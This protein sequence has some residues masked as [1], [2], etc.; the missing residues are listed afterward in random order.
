MNT[1]NYTDLIKLKTFEERFEYLRLRGKVG[2]DTFGFDRYLNQMLYHSAEWKNFKKEILVRDL[3]HD[4]AMESDDYIIPG[5][6]TVHHII[7][8]TA[9]DVIDSSPM[10]FDPNNVVCVSDKTH[11]AIHYGVEPLLPKTI[12]QRKPGDTLLW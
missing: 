4:L 3:G 9:Q 11:K 6:I 1:R 5:F 12:I 8:I 7:P 10:I 2:E